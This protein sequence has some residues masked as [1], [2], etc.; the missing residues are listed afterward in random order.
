[1]KPSLH[2]VSWVGEMGTYLK[3][4]Y[5][6]AWRKIYLFFFF[7]LGFLLFCFYEKFFRKELLQEFP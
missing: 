5:S 2:Q 3:K 4:I 7:F 1:M 6:E